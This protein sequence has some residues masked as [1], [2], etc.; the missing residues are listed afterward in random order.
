MDVKKH[1]DR[2]KRLHKR[3]SQWHGIWQE[4]ADVLLPV[5]ADIIDDREPG[6]AR[7]QEL[8]DGTPIQAR[9]GLATAIDGLLK[10]KTSRWFHI[11]ATE[12]DLNDDDEAK[13]WLQEVEERM[14]GAIYSREARF[15]QRSGEVDNDL[16]TFGTGILFIGENQ[17]LNNLV[18][19][20]IHPKSIAIAENADGV[21]DTLWVSM[22]LTPRQAAQKWGEENLGE[23]TKEKLQNESS[24]DEK[25]EFIQG[26]FPREERDPQRRDN[27]NLPF[28]S[29]I[30]DVKSEHLVEE[31][32]FHEFPFAVPRWET[33]SGEVYGRSPGMVALP[34]SKTLQAMGK[35]MLVAGQKATDPPLWVLDDSVIGVPRTFPGGVTVID[36]EATRNFG[37]EPFGAMDFGKNIPLGFEMQRDVRQQI[38]AAFFRNVFRLPVDGPQMTATEVRERKEEFIRTIGPVFGQ[39]EADYIGHIVERV[40]GI[41]FRAGAFPEPP[42]ILQGRDIRFEFQSPVQQARKQIEAASA[43]QSIQMMAPFIE[44]DPSIMDNFNGDEMV[45][46]LP[47]ATGFPMDWLRSDQEV[48]QLRQRRQ[49]QQ[50]AQQAL[51]AGGQLSQIG[52]TAAEAERTAREGEPA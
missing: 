48:Q 44:A 21:V 20:S 28:A 2:W 36:S 1:L 5:R 42:E 30:I 31:S 29:V 43:A 13:E 23:K 17:K 15:I 33:A 18:F 37:R 4:L 45:R 46:S 10:S 32:G 40:F 6:Q 14:W 47:D 25:C 41:L 12:D 3:A 35:T 9:R 7:T 51:E 52:K 34:D 16:V 19:R 11:R 27:L 38:E 50:Q 39:L 26:V 22:K 24:R 8:Y 49:Q